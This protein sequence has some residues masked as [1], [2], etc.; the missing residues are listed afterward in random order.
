MKLR[1]YL[2]Y[3]RQGLRSAWQLAGMN[4][5]MYAGLRFVA[6]ILMG[7]AV[8]HLISDRVHAESEAADTRVA[9]KV[10]SQAAYI[11]SLEA[12]VAACLSDGLG[13][14]VQVG[15]EWVLCGTYPLGKF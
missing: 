15:D 13:R 8:M 4:A 11:A 14:P 1:N 5:V 10:A 7:L 3:R 9:A 6:V 12:V 2:E